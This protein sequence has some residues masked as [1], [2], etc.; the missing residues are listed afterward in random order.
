[1]HSCRD[2]KCPARY[3]PAEALE[4]AV[5]DDLCRLLTEPGA[6][7]WA[8]ERAHGGH[9]LPQEL[10]ARREGLRRGA[11]A[12]RQALERL[13]TAYLDGVLGL[14]LRKITIGAP[15]RWTRRRRGS[16]SRQ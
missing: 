13:T 3:A 11:A 10:Q 6:I 15:R 16:G 9:W 12:L 14:Q 1:M 2:T 4:A 5:W 8:L 7:R